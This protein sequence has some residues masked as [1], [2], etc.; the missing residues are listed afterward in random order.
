MSRKFVYICSPLSG[1]VEKNTEKA[2]E[3]CRD[4]MLLFPEVVPIAP[5]IYFPQFLDET[6]PI[7]RSLGMEAGI[8]LLEFCEEIWV[9]GV[10]NPTAGMRQEI[11]Y[12]KLHGLPIKNGFKELAKGYNKGE[13]IR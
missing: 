11:E 10:A 6:D 5:H 12:A 3:Y 7:E 1:D 4:A 2:R 8:A 9:F 13:S